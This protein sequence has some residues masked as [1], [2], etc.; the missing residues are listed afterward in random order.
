MTSIKVLNSYL[1]KLRLSR[2]LPI[3]FYG[4]IHSGTM[5]KKRKSITVDG[6]IEDDELLMMGSHPVTLAEPQR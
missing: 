1:M 5:K 2:H 3:G 4:C 6:V